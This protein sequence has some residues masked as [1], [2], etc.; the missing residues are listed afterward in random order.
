MSCFCFT[1][2]GFHGK[3]VETIIKDLVEVSVKVTK[4]AIV[5]ENRDLFERRVD[6]GLLD[7]IVWTLTQHQPLSAN[8]T[9]THDHL[10]SSHITSTGLGSNGLGSHTSHPGESGNLPGAPSPLPPVPPSPGA[11][12]GSGVL[13]F[14]AGR[15]GT[16]TGSG[17]A[18]VGSL[19]AGGACSTSGH[20]P[21]SSA[22]SQAGAA[23]GVAAGLAS[24]TSTPSRF[25]AA[26]QTA[27]LRETFRGYL[28]DGSLDYLVVD[29]ELNISDIALLNSILEQERLEQEHLERL[30]VGEDQES[31]AS[32]IF[33]HEG[34]REDIKGKAGATA[35]LNSSMNP[36]TARLYLPTSQTTTNQT[37]IANNEG[38][39]KKLLEDSRVTRAAKH[40]KEQHATAADNAAGSEGSMGE[41]KQPVM[42]SSPSTPHASSSSTP[43][44]PV[45]KAPTTPGRHFVYI[46]HAR[47]LLVER[48]SH[49]FAESASANLDHLAVLNAEQNGIVFL[50]EIDK[51]CV[52]NK[53]MR[54]GADASDEGVQRD[55]LPII[56]GSCVATP[57]GNVNTDHI[58]F[59]ASGAFHQV[60]PS[61]LL[62]ELQGRLPIRVQLS[63]LTENELFLVLT[64][65]Q[66]NLL[67]QQVALMATEGVKLR[68]REDAAKEMA[69]VACELNRLH[70]NMGA[71]RLHAILEKVMEEVSFTAADLP[72]GTEVII[73][74]ELVKTRVQDMLNK[75]D[76]TRYIL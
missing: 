7:K 17:I 64:Q 29:V 56:E 54:T 40:G 15:L 35:A 13:S 8:P 44:L 71:R 61:D 31:S 42:A 30:R 39:L 26:A 70:E 52:S 27:Q 43:L 3:D 45:F 23:A 19:P 66:Q 2:A 55:L 69:K 41:H 37:V 68:F 36:S 50:D 1:P 75:V 53:T 48:E 60:K 72:P 59:I 76:I 63:P 57:R 73:T 38:Q 9:R 6:E 12:T 22:A 5:E 74:K 32:A 47:K 16:P 67:S 65:P 58:L 24:G 33:A 62:P 21:S 34:K 46:K 4:Q 18:G 10:S 11:V 28:H 14:D 51:I 25:Q 49:T 20:S